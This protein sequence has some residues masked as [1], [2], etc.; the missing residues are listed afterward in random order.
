[1]HFDLPHLKPARE[2]AAT[3]DHGDR[4]KYMSGCRCVPCRA[5]NSRYETERAAAR[6]RGEWNGLIDAAEVREHLQTLS[7]NGIGRD[8]VAD[9]TGLCVST[10][11]LYFNGK[12]Q[13]IR[14]LNAA[15][16]LAISPDEILND[17]QLISAKPTWEKIRW[18]L[19]AGFTKAELAR[20]L[21][22]KNPALQINKKRITTRTALRIERFYKT[23]RLGDDEYYG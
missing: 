21:G 18:M 13:K 7:G 10:I 20:R 5:A 3:R 14:A 23:I 12:R 6:K 19:R 15:K 1:M 2:L 22:Y 17:A 11:S 16:I 4:L 9:I 8:T